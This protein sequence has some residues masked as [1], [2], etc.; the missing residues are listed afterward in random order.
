MST[1]RSYNIHEDCE[2]KGNA[3][4]NSSAERIDEDNLKTRCAA[5][6]YLARREYSER[7]LQKKLL[8]KG[9]S[10]HSIQATLQQLIQEKFL[11]DERF[12]EAFITNRLRQGYGPVRIAL[13]LRQQG[14]SEETITSQLQQ[15][16][17]V[18]LDCIKKIQQKKFSSPSDN[19]KE[20]LRQINYLQYRGFRLDQIKESF[21]L[22]D[23]N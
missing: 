5:L 23:K 11:N 15:N 22:A 4:K 7:M 2:L 21:K 8:Q 10:P 1:L 19:L 17:S 18:W 13:E 6:S 9:F 20:K 3:D 16:E 12:C 14:V